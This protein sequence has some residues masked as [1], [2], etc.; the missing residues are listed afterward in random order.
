MKNR[1]LIVLLLITSLF[2]YLEWG[3]D[4]SSFLFKLEFDVLGK[5]ISNPVSVLHPFVILPLLGQ[6]LLLIALFFNS[7]GKWLLFAGI[8]FLSLLPAVI[9]LVGLLSV[10]I[11]IL[12][13]LLPYLVVLILVVKRIIIST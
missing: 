6:M 4:N 7:P 12:L 9:L 13:S 2:V 8:V 5:L 11:K 10:N 1:L 3:G